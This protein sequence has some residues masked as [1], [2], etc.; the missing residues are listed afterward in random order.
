MGVVVVDDGS[1]DD[2]GERVQRLRDRQDRIRL[3]SHNSNRG[4]GAALKTGFGPRATRTCFTRMAMGSSI[5][6][7]SMSF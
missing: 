7:S 6:A 5:C 3:V 1:A 4:Y 2:T